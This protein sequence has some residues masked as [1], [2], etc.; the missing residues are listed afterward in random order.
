[1][2]A[3]GLY[4]NQSMILTKVDSENAE[5][6]I[7]LLC[8]KAKDNGCIEPVFVDAILAREKE[9][10][11]GLPTAVPIAM[12]HIHDGC[13]RSFFSMA[14]LNQPVT[15]Q[16]MGDPD[17]AVET[18]LVFVFGITDPSYQTAV[19]KKFSTIFQSEEALNNLLGTETEEEL[20]KK[21]K[22]FLDEYL[23]TDEI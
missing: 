18:R 10:P 9:Y 23:I 19:L 17:E 11:T 8:E 21:M 20:M 16:C 22:S 7:R 6:V 3:V 4:A 12:P 5:G 13:L 1:M 14:V 15:F 2:E